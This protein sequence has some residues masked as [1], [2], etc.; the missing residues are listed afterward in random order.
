MVASSLTTC[1]V[2]DV[3]ETGHTLLLKYVCRIDMCDM[4]SVGETV[5][6]MCNEAKQVTKREESSA[7][8]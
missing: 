7:F 3:A 1:A 8:F 2:Q 4:T 5:H 6:N